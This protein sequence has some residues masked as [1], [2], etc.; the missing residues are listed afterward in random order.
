MRFFTGCVVILTLVVV[1]FLLFLRSENPQCNERKNEVPQYPVYPS[2][3]LLGQIKFVDTEES[4]VYTYKY[5][6][7]STMSNFIDW[8]EQSGV[9]CRTGEEAQAYVCHGD[10]TPFGGYFVTATA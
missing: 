10:V 4:A 2:S 7:A 5:S 1:A 6:T 9:T 3:S 8:Y